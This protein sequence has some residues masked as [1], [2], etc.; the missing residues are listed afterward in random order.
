MLLTIGV[1]ATLLVLVFA[2][3]VSRAAHEAT[4]PRRSENR[5]FAAM[6]NTLLTS[7]NGVDGHLSYLLTH[8]QTL[9][10][11]VF[12]ARLD[13]II[14]EFPQWLNEAQLLRRPILA[15]HVNRVIAQVTETR[16]DA[17]VALVNSVTTALSLPLRGATTSPLEPAAA[18]A[19]LVRS[20]TQWN[21][22]RWSLVKEP[23]RV[24]LDALT[25][26][27]AGL[28]FAAVLASLTGS[29]SLALTRGIG[30]TALEVTPAALPA[31]VGELLMP[32][33]TTV[34]LGITVTNGAYVDQPVVVTVT[35]VPL[36]GPLATQH[37]VLSATLGPLGSYAFAPSGLA[38]VAG[39]RA[40]LIISATGAPAAAGMVSR[41]VYHV[42]LSPSG[43]G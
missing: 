6:A 19:A 4:G 41:R 22:S 43:N 3:D 40:T 34:N 27:V 30:I 14:E 35:L 5:T 25:S 8:G 18:Q 24:H 36:N 31:P 29:S 15:H 38:T 21:H 33:V 17:Y 42:T 26:S 23:G 9:S 32:P 11:P 16:I 28:S 12:A 13:Q 37:M 2:H 1:I 7:E 10:R 20:D 39:E